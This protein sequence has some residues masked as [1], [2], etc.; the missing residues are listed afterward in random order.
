MNEHE[1]CYVLKALIE[2]GAVREKA[3][4]QAVAEGARFKRA[5][6]QLGRLGDKDTADASVR[7]GIRDAAEGRGKVMSFLKKGRRKAKGPKRKRSPKF[8]AAVRLCG[9]YMGR[10]KNLTAKQRAHVRAVKEK[11]GIRAAIAEAKRLAA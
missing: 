2:S 5:M 1:C 10:T 3:V 7:R 6:E 4:R 8:L 11:N 9:A